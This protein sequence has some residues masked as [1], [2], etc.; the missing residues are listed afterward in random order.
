VLLGA[1]PP[2]RGRRPDAAMGADVVIPVRR[3]PP[4]GWPLRR[5]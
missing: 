2:G 4:P 3:T 5:N 1:A